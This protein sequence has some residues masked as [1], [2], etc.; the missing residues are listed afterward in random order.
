MSRLSTAL[1]NMLIWLYLRIKSFLS[2]PL[3]S[4]QKHIN[5]KMTHNGRISFNHSFLKFCSAFS[6]L[7]LHR[8]A[9]DYSTD[10]VSELTFGLPR[11]WY[12]PPKVFV[13]LLHLE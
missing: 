6:S 5:E 13:T 1:S 7:Q 10:T 2:T 3:P 11:G 9:P 4:T 8:G 12:P